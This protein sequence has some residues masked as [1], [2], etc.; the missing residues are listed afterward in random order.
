VNVFNLQGGTS[1]YIS[2][3]KELRGLEFTKGSSSELIKMLANK[4]FLKADESGE[5]IILHDAGMVITKTKASEKPIPDN[6]P[7]HLARLF[8]YNDIMRKVGTNYLSKDFINDDLIYEAATAYVV[9]P[10]SSLTVL[11]TQQ[12][13]KRFD[14]QDS[15]SSLGNAAKQSSGAVP[16][17][18][19]WALI[20]LFCLFAVYLKFKS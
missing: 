1:T 17:P 12:D 3:F 8:A 18:H 2:S 9:S 20:I 19:E 4:T 14:I 16:E 7:D 10:V 5:R 15:K 6:A 11:E 13:Y